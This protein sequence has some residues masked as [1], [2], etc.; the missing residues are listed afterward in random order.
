[1]RSKEKPD[2]IKLLNYNLSYNPVFENLYK[3]TSK[4]L[5]EQ[6]GE[7]IAQ[8]ARIRSAKHIKRGDYLDV[9]NNG[10]TQRGKVADVQIISN[11]STYTAKVTLGLGNG[12]AIVVE[13]EVLHDRK[14]LINQASLAGVDYYSDYITDVEYARLVDYTG[15]YWKHQN[16]GER[17]FIDFIGFIKGMRLSLIQLW[18][19]DQGDYASSVEP[20]FDFYEYLR[21]EVE[22]TDPVR[23]EEGASRGTEYLTSHVDMEYDVLAS[24]NV[25]FNDLINLFYYFA[26]IELVLNRIV[27]S[28]STEVETH[29]TVIPQIDGMFQG[30]YTWTPK[31]NISLF[32][33]PPISQVDAALHSYLFLDNYLEE[34]DPKYEKYEHSWAI[35]SRWLARDTDYIANSRYST[36]TIISK[37][38]RYG[39]KAT[40]IAI[41]IGA[42]SYTNMRVTSSFDSNS[43]TVVYV[44]STEFNGTNN[45][46]VYPTIRKIAAHRAS[47][48]FSVSY[49]ASYFTTTIMQGVSDFTTHTTYYGIHHSEATTALKAEYSEAFDDQ[50]FDEGFM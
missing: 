18:T 15:S 30:S 23:L 21:P 43:Y 25:L 26:P 6:I 48:N 36:R 44:G 47:S 29:G 4:I 13:K 50:A 2:F 20:G 19:V 46:V 9:D 37:Q 38:I 49:T 16:S 3:S 24:P 14:T 39:A 8:L 35:Q 42:S 17:D 7:P 12:T 40:H 11:G 32:Y 27:G 34:R 22:V 45:F 41:P 5:D 33:T 31:T 10:T 1:M 28:I